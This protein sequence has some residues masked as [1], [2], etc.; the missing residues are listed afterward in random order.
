MRAFGICATL[1]LGLLITLTANNLLAT[2]IDFRGLSQPISPVTVAGITVNLSPNGALVSTPTSFGVDSVGALDAPT[3]LD[4]GNGFAESLAFLFLQ[5]VIVD[6]VVISAF[7]PGDAGTISIKGHPL[8]FVSDGVNT[9]GLLS[10]ATSA[11]FISWSGPNVPG[12]LLGFSVDG[13]NVHL[14]PE[15]STVAL[16][17]FGFAILT[18]WGWRRKRDGLFLKS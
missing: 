17:A 5:N 10:N 6:S 12:D 18:A 11:N 16:A 1:T 13:L 7:D 3:L 4:G 14:V 15:P 8:V 2:F 9:V